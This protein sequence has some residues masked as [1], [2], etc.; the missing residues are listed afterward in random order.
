MLDTVA[1]R[2][3]RQ[4]LDRNAH[5][6]PRL[7]HWMIGLAAAYLLFL[8]LIAF[9]PTPVDGSLEG[10]LSQLLRWVH[11]HG[12]PHWLSYSLVEFTA[13]IALFI[14]V[15]LF[16]V[17]LAGK[18]RWWLGIAAG[19]AASCTIE[20][21]QLIFLPARFATLND[22]LANT[23]GSVIGVLLGLLVLHLASDSLEPTSPP[24]EFPA[25]IPR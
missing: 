24:A 25:P 22:V 18:S 6:H 13:N 1:E 19:F 7:R 12:A 8:T 10:T 3:G 11:A 15:G 23:S 5:R 20:L 17:V 16:I 14:P 4:D 9:W 21:G 2:R